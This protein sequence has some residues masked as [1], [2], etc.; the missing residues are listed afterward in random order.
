MAQYWL[1]PRAAADAAAQGAGVIV[2]PAPKT[3]LDRKHTADGT[4]AS[5]AGVV[6]TEVA[7]GPV[8]DW[9]T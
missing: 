7:Y 9:P 4:G 1:D 6:S 3:Y 8:I 5:W 2:S